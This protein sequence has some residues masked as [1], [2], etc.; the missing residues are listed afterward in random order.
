MQCGDGS[1]GV[2]GFR[3]ASTWSGLFG[4]FPMHSAGGSARREPR[5]RCMGSGTWWERVGQRGL[6]QGGWVG[7]YSSIISFLKQVLSTEAPPY[8]RP[9]TG[10]QLDEA[11]RLGLR[12]IDVLHDIPESQHLVIPQV[13]ELQWSL[14]AG[15]PIDGVTVMNRVLS[16]ET[17]VH[18]DVEALDPQSAW[19]SLTSGWMGLST[20]LQAPRLCLKAK[21]DW[22]G[23]VSCESTLR[24]LKHH[25]KW[26]GDGVDYGICDVGLR[27]QHPKEPAPPICVCFHYHMPLLLIVGLAVLLWWFGRSPALIRWIISTVGRLATRL[28]GYVPVF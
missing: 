9:P 28:P 3:E 15:Q 16:G 11:H 20:F 18:D 26:S 12:L 2:D 7:N 23:N 24:C 21:T 1:T 14:L 6:S 25:L 22:R 27:G 4:K 8:S 5:G 19:S 13:K 17:R 10:E